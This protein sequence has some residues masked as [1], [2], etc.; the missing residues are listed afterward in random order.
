MKRRGMERGRCGSGQ[1]AAGDD[2]VLVF[3]ALTLA[4]HVYLGEGAEDCGVQGN[5]LVYFSNC[6]SL[7]FRFSPLVSP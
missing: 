6:I 7:D 5:F 3:F 4:L 2:F 1:A